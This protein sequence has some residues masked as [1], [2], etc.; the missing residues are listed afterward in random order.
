MIYRKYHRLFGGMDS[1]MLSKLSDIL[2]DKDCVNHVIYFT[3]NGGET[4]ISNIMISMIKHYNHINSGKRCLIVANDILFSNG[5][6]FCFELPKSCIRYQGSLQGMIHR[7][8]ISTDITGGGK[9][10]DAEDEARKDFITF[11]HKEDLKFY[12]RIG[13]SAAELKK[14]EKGEDVFLSHERMILLFKNNGIKKFN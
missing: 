14:V 3:S 5:F 4:R 6:M 1:D 7:A 11:I 8:R 9:Y 2:N 12:N 13:I 10:G